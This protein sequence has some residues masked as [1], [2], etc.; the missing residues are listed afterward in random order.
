MYMDSPKNRTHD[1]IGQ[2]TISVKT[3]GHDKTRFTLMLC[4]DNMG[5]KLKPT[6]IFR[7]LKKIPKGCPEGIHVM[8]GIF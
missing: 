2:T 7:G 4:A 3:T 8:T 1:F 6:I 5:R